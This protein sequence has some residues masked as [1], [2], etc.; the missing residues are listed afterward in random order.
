MIQQYFRHHSLEKRERE[1]R[2]LP[3]A[4]DTYQRTA[5]CFAYFAKRTE[6][7]HFIRFE[8]FKSIRNLFGRSANW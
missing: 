5:P 2:F 4:G 6:N 3:V 8:D 7:W 1:G